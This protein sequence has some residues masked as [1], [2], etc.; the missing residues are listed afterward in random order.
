MVA[1]LAP[2]RVGGALT[3]LAERGV[4]SWVLGW[5][6][7]PPDRA[8]LPPGADQDVTQGAKGVDGGSV[9]LVGDHPAA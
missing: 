9:R 3:L 5:V 7:L 6:G 1:V 2:D 8:G 4:P